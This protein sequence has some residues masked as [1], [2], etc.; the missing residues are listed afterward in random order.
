MF[1]QSSGQPSVAR[2]RR[3]AS[4]L[5][6]LFAVVCLTGLSARAQ[7]A[8]G[9][10]AEA[11]A[12]A[13]ATVRP[14]T[15]SA[16]T[17]E[18]PGLPDLVEEVTVSAGI[19]REGRDPVTFTSLGRDEISRRNRGQDLAMILAETPNAYA[20]S[21]AGNGVGY[22]YLRL[23]G[24]D[25]R[26]IAVN[27]NGIPL[28]TPESHQ[29]YFIDLADLAGA[30]ATL[31]VQRGTSTLLYGAPAVGGAVNLDF[32][33]LSTEPGGEVRVGG[34]SFGTRRA[35]LRYGG[36]LAG[37]RWAWSA[38][39][40]RVTSDG[41]RQNAWTRHTLG[42]LQMQRFG[43]DSSLRINLYGGP[44]KTQLSYFGVPIEY[45]RGEITGDADRDRRV[46]F[47]RPGETDEYF[48]PHLEL[49]YDRRLSDAWSLRAALY[50]ILGDGAYRQYDAEREFITAYDGTGYPVSSVTV[51]DAWRKRW[52]GERQIGAITHVTRRAGRHT[53]QAGLQLR[54]HASHHQGTL[55]EGRFAGPVDSRTLYDYRNRKDTAIAFVRDEIEIA[56]AL[57]VNLELQG[58]VHRFRMLDDRVRGLGYHATY[59]FLNPRVALHWSAAPGLGLYASVS[60]ASSEPPF[61]DLWDQQDPYVRPRD[62]F[63]GGRADGRFFTDPLA[64]PER[65]RSYEAGASYAFARG[66]LKAN[67]YRMDFKDELVFAGGLDDDGNPVT[68]NAGRSLHRGL[69]VEGRALLPLLL[70]FAGS[71]AFSR[72][73]LKSLRLRGGTTVDY[74]GNR[75][76]LF[77]DRLLS[78]RLA[79]TFGP[80]RAEIGVRRVGTI[81]LDNSENERR[82][83]E[84][85]ATPG[86]VDKKIDPFTLAE[87]DVSIDL[88]RFAASGA[89]VL[90]ART[91]TLD[92]GVQNLF[93]RRYAAFGYSYP[94]ATF[95]SFYTEFFPGAPRSWSAGV[96]AR[97]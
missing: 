3:V 32:G 13:D 80:V 15:D 2:A 65:V 66:S 7:S 62:L 52:I 47:L 16:P 74:S 84:L 34:G 28:N 72:D 24:F 17:R 6:L 54:A 76:A 26:R 53:L 5:G 90:G 75:I 46:N 39:V 88:S 20:Y 48:Q 81:Y 30:A 11:D 51:E 79:R 96:T 59:D 67:V 78:A 82:S 38:R 36:P 45:L 43:E 86:Y 37:G 49:I 19:A 97:F 9:A 95:S 29:V 73:E 61:R 10:A 18:K 35:S 87:V 25:Q 70:E 94:D 12:D 64:R 69:E 63:G 68:T 40:S 27:V 92:L 23:R 77:P 33:S 60:T 22:S 85:R 57:R 50:T 58:T 44:E 31:Q 41:Y 8:P 56:D 1:V 71:A 42:M 83:P 14:A 89:R 93:D 21:D 91:L 4:R 55:I